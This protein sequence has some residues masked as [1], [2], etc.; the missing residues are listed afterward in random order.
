MDGLSINFSN[1][2]TPSTF[3]IL[4]TLHFTGGPKAAFGSAVACGILLGVFEGVGVL[5]GRVFSE[6]TRPQ[7]PPCEFFL[8]ILIGATHTSDP[9]YP[10]R[11]LRNRH[12]LLCS[13]RYLLSSTPS[14][15]MLSLHIVPWSALGRFVSLTCALID[16]MLHAAL[17]RIL[18]TQH[19]VISCVNRLYSRH[20]TGTT[21][22]KIHQ[23]LAFYVCYELRD[24][25]TTASSLS[26]SRLSCSISSLCSAT[27]P[28]MPSA[29]RTGTIKTC[30]SSA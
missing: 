10:S 13:S 28:S 2:I 15:V 14:S 16:T 22:A 26:T 20:T 27:M 19:I 30:F 18:L 8:S 29:A 7:L 17:R 21:R 12:H 23:D 25:E 9:Q 5:L 1:S 11:C 6:G 24:S 4:L 3:D